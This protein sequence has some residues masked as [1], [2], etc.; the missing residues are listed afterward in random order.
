MHIMS[1]N[2]NLELCKNIAEITETKISKCK[3][4]D[5]TPFHFAAQT[6]NFEVYQFLSENL[7]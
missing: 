5:W 7:K 3:E 6:G 4:D 2:G 1:E